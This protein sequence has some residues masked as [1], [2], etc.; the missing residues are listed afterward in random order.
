M[1]HCWSYFQ[2]KTE[3]KILRNSNF[4]FYCNVSLIIKLVFLKSLSDTR[5]GVLSKT[6]GISFPKISY[7]FGKNLF[8]FKKIHQK[9]A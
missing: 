9:S 7:T 8:V 3:R 6:R 2:G 1:L 4:F 5:G